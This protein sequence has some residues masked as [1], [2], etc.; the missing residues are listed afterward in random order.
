MTH[1]YCTRIRPALL[2]SALTFAVGVLLS[3]TITGCSTQA[4]SAPAFT[5]KSVDS[6]QPTASATAVVPHDAKEPSASPDETAE[7]STVA[8]GVVTAFCRPTLDR[9]TWI[10]NLYP[11]LSQSA[12]VAYGTVDPG[13]V[14]CTAVTGAA[15][16]RDT[17]GSY[18]TRVFVPTDAGEYSV[19]LNRSDTTDLWLVEQITP[20]VG[21]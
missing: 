6:L 5:E 17:D 4:D 11:F 8:V 7:V 14:P 20:Y 3:T 16:I 9:H 1:S 10:N 13:R 19:L 2:R 18:T 15:R 12:A 21:G